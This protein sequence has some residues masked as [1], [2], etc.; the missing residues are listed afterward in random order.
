LQVD[1]FVGTR[2]ER[3]KKI[4]V[5]FGNVTG[6]AEGVTRP[7]QIFLLSGT[8]IAFRLVGTGLLRAEL[9][10]KRDREEFFRQLFEE[11]RERI[12][13]IARRYTSNRDDALDL[14]QEVF[15]K[16][17]RGLEQIHS[18]ANM[19]GWIYRIA[20][21]TCIDYVRRRQTH[22]MC[23]F[24][25]FVENGGTLPSQAHSPEQ[26]L[27]LCELKENLRSVLETLSPEH[28]AV[29]LLH[30]LEDVPYK[31]IAKVL[32]CSIGI[33]MSRLHYA[34][35]NVERGLRACDLIK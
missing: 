28:R 24:D 12:Y 20:V 9:R 31:G 2:A 23:S 10:V 14:V 13:Y 8:G 16:V 26:E 3:A 33:V 34:R 27:V 1:N 29:F 30:C 32:H 22:S 7:G 21:N 19:R 15:I 18:E 6:G 25:E 17:Y 4:A 35:R 5:R 11:F